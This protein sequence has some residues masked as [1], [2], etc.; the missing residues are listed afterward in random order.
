M[1]TNV[2]GDLTFS[3]LSNRNKCLQMMMRYGLI[4]QETDS[5]WHW[6]DQGGDFTGIAIADNDLALEIPDTMYYRFETV[7]DVLLASAESGEFMAKSDECKSLFVWFNGKQCTADENE[8]ESLYLAQKPDNYDI[9]IIQDCLTMEDEEFEDKHP[10]ES[11][12]STL[13]E[14]MDGAAEQVLTNLKTRSS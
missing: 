12:S 13:W 7:Q 1:F 2:C 8:L 4:K 3:N 5:E 6:I 14:I 9:D 10:N 11:Y